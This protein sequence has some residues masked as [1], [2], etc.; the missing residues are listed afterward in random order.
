VL[1][2]KKRNKV[3]DDILRAV[4]KGKTFLLSGHHKPDGDTVGSELAFASFL[5]RLKKKVRIVNAEPVPETLR[6]LPGVDRIEA[7]KKVE[8]HFDVVVVFECSGADRMGNILDLDTQAG[9]VVNIDHHRHHAYFGD[10]NLIDPDASSNSEQLFHFFER[11]KMKITKDEAAALYVGLVTDTGRFQQEN[12]NPESH[13]VA[14]GLHEAGIDV[15]EISRKLYGTRSEAALRVLGRGVSSLKLEAG[16]RVAVLMVTE[17]DFAETGAGP[18][19]TED[20]VNHGLLIPSVE[21]AVFV[22]PTET[23]GDSK[24]SFRGK[25]RVDLCA[26]A[27]SLNG[28]GHRNASGCNIRADVPAAARKATDAVIAALPKA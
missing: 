27:V 20:V 2:I 10:I 22:R 3:V 26:V 8:G 19:D 15:A 25:G 7:L 4:R 1:P 28:G 21:A 9:V 13:R 5:R 18:D 16:G 17:K 24:V 6:F 14:A 12:A 11:A 23:P